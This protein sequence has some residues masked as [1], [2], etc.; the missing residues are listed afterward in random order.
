MRI[1]ADTYSKRLIGRIVRHYLK[2]DR[3]N[4]FITIA[5]ILAFL[6]ITAGVMVLMIAMGIMNGMQDEFQNRLFIMNYPLTVVSYGRGVRE[7]TIRK[8]REKF[9]K[10][11]ISPYYSTQ[12]IVRN[13]NDVQGCLLYGV[14]FKKE[15]KINSV[16]AKATKDIN[17]TSRYSIVIGDDLSVVLGAPIGSKILLYFSKQR[18]IGF[19]TAPLQKHFRVV[20][21]YN[22]GLNSYDKAII[23]TTTDAFVKL[24]KKDPKRYD[25]VHIYV[26]N[27][28]EIIDDIKRLL[29]DD[30]GVEGWWQQN[31]NFFSAMEMEKKALF[32]VLLL[33]ILVASL[34]IVS[35]LLMT[36]M[37][38]RSEIA[39]LRT[40][41]AT[42]KEI[43][44]IFFKLGMSIGL[45]G[46]VTGT[47]LGIVGGWILRHFD[48][49]T[50]PA[51][52]YGTTH[53][54]VDMN[55]SDSLY[56]IGGTFIITLLSSIYPAKKAASTDPLSVLRNE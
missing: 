7:D 52:V 14:D 32:L 13:D 51:D 50:L 12:V 16:F 49:I 40:L 27:P 29:P 2:Y 54:P 42:Q 30:A 1:D 33:I 15:A 37:S 6:G 48:I 56:I 21:L 31:G 25:G 45:A 11:G 47:I 19:S 9:P 44:T 10:A 18:A 23:Y 36:V 43:Y 17:H 20:A 38:R 8:I 5:A 3:D 35:S 28:M 34:N 4:P 26:D 22:S 53:L 41:G 46:I 39:L 24:L 55:L